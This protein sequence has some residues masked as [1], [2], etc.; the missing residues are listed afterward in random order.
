M[1]TDLDGDFHYSGWGDWCINGTYR[2]D[3][4]EQSSP[5]RTFETTVTV[6]TSDS[7]SDDGDGDTGD[8]DDDSGSNPLDDVIGLL[9]SAR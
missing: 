6:S 4:T 3:G 9:P 5:W 7:S 1:E 2:V 8:S